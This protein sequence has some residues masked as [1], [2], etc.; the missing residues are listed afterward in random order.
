M[1]SRLLKNHILFQQGANWM[2]DYPITFHYV[3]T[4]QMYHLEYY[5]YHLRPYGIESSSQDLNKPAK[6]Q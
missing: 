3:S 4:Q 2:S 6:S 1:N 5:I